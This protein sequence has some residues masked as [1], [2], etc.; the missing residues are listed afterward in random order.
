MSL[1]TLGLSNPSSKEDVTVGTKALD[2]TGCAAWWGSAALKKAA[3]APTKAKRARRG[4]KERAMVV[5]RKG[6]MLRFFV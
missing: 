3:V 2:I 1:A 5:K 4:K 6:L